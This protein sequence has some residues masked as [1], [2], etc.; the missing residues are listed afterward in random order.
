MLHEYPDILTVG[1]LQ[2][3]LKIGRNT[4]YKLL[5]DNVIKSKRIGKIHKIPKSN[6]IEYLNKEK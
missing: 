3:V 1:Q 6:V 2:Q 4:A 5:N